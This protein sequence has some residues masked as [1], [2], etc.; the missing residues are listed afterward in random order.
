MNWFLIVGDTDPD[1]V[2]LFSL[3]L[4]RGATRVTMCLTLHGKWTCIS[5]AGFQSTDHSRCF[6]TLVTFTQSFINWWQ[7]LSCK[8][9]TIRSSLGLSML[10]KDTF[11]CSQENRTCSLLITGWPTLPPEPQPPNVWLHSFFFIS[12]PPVPHIEVMTP[13]THF[14]KNLAFI[15]WLCWGNREG[16]HHGDLFCFLSIK[17]HKRG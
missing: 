1:S 17:Q 6:T 5:I 4:H 11:T 9:S 15:Q 10:L 13:L 2:N 7:R 14:S 3:P 16:C 12:C 8:V